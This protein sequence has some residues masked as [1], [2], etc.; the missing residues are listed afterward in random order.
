MIEAKTVLHSINP[1]GEEIYTVKITFPRIILAELNTHRMFSRNSASSRAIP[2]EKMVKSVKENPFIPIAWQKH[3]KGMQGT[4]Y[5]TGFKVK[6][7]RFLW[8]LISRIVISCA[9]VLNKLQLTKQLANRLLE[10]FML[11]TVLITAT[12][13]E[14]FFKLRCPRY[15][16]DGKCYRSWEDITKA[17]FNKQ[18][19][20]NYVRVKKYSILDRLKTNKGDSEIHMMLLAEAIWDAYNS[21]VPQKL[22]ENEWHIP[23]HKEI[24]EL[25]KSD[26]PYNHY[27]GDLYE[28]EIEG[29][30]DNV[31]ATRDKI[32]VSSMM[33]ARVSYTVIGD[34]Q[35]SWS[36]DKYLQKGEELEKA[37]PLHASPLE[38]C[39]KVPTLK[40]YMSRVKGQISLDEPLDKL[41]ET[42]RDI[43]GW[44]RNFKGFIQY[45][46]LIE[47]WQ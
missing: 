41:F 36:F 10:P 24:M 30:D 20:G 14:N 22:K 43:F 34:D 8:L 5:H 29:T 37:D 27:L 40:E 17:V 28:Y 42:N 35:K 11:H 6:L 33:S 23:F 26:G 44:S 38:H 3:H 12:D 32:K 13:W 18:A 47:R 15:E 16:Y 46:E 9:V 19:S 2:F 7:F 39:A 45:R 21:S 1:W 31:R 4:E 25:M